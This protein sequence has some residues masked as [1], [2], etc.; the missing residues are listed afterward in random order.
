MFIL[1]FPLFE[2]RRHI[3]VVSAPNAV[4]TIAA[5]AVLAAVEGA[6]VLITITAGTACIATLALDAIRCGKG[7]DATADDYVQPV[8]L[9][10]LSGQSHRG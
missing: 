10:T 5:V 3:V 1:H 7:T 2:Q 8:A 9:V 6:R 4:I